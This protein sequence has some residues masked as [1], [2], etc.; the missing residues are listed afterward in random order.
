MRQRGECDVGDTLDCIHVDRLTLSDR[1]VD[2]PGQL[3]K[4]V[5]DV[6]RRITP[7]RQIRQMRAGMARQDAD[8]VQPGVAGGTDDGSWAPDGKWGGGA[9]R[10]V[11]TAL[12]ALSL[13]VYYRYL[14]PTL[15]QTGGR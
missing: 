7:A 1:R 14:P 4:L 9:G 12:G 3:R 6:W 5:T 8:K 15:V 11:T 10:V 2:A 13:E